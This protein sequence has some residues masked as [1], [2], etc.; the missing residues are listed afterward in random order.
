MVLRRDD[1]EDAGP[2]AELA[3]AGSARI[4]RSGQVEGA[5]RSAGGLI[6]VH[7]PL[8]GVV[9]LDGP[10]GQGQDVVAG[11]GRG[12]RQGRTHPRPRCEIPLLPS[13]QIQ[14]KASRSTKRLAIS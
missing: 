12:A 6:D 1:G 3:G 2:V 7:A 8:T 10:P 5:H 4:A 14:G 13:T 9:L 11:H